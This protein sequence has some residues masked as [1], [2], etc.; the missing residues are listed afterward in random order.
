MALPN[1]GY[2]SAGIK[3]II[4]YLFFV[5]V[6]SKKNHLESKINKN[7]LDQISRHWHIRSQLVIY[8]LSSAA[9]LLHLVPL[10]R[11]FN[12]V[13]LGLGIWIRPSACVQ[14]WSRCRCSCAFL[15]QQEGE[16]A[17]FSGIWL[18]NLKSGGFLPWCSEW[19]EWGWWWRRMC[20]KCSD[21]CQ[22][23]IK[24]TDIVLVYGL[25]F[26]N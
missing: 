2:L 8:G 4:F 12:A 20:F 17:P 9:I 22:V 6:F 5:A 14:K 16:Q 11:V 15:L 19:C 24:K 1:L 10:M 21:N 13:T 23:T 25:W 26:K 7:N 18:E 3:W